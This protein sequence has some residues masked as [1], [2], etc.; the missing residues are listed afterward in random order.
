MLKKNYL[1]IVAVLLLAAV[2]VFFLTRKPV[3][4]APQP[5][6]SVEVEKD[7]AKPL[8]TDLTDP[9]LL[10][11]REAAD[12]FRDPRLKIL[13][14]QD[15]YTPS[16]EDLAGFLAA[17]QRS[18]ESLL[19]AYAVCKDPRVL[20]ELMTAAPSERTF[21]AVM[22]WSDDDDTVA[23]AT[24][25]MKK[26]SPKNPMPYLVEVARGGDLEPEQLKKVLE[27]IGDSPKID[28]SS[29]R[30]PA[31]RDEAWQSVVKDPVK[32]WAYSLQSMN[33]DL[34]TLDTVSNGILDLQ[35]SSQSDG[36]DATGFTKTLALS[37]ALRSDSSEISSIADPKVNG[38]EL[39]ILGAVDPESKYPGTSIKVQERIDQLEAK[40]ADEDSLDN[41]MQ[42]F[43]KAADPA[44]VE[45]FVTGWRTNGMN[46]ALKGL[47][48]GEKH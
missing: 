4:S 23:K 17:H 48:D 22:L 20:D 30:Q 25:E 14:Q 43:L 11:K 46:A 28:L 16:L 38:L 12:E 34:E 32:S 45:T 19:A 13:S 21:Q 3:A 37:K 26:L 1:W 10:P 35:M 7:P 2:A 40:M 6:P 5:P 29:L 24:E 33:L 18:P 36:N 44:A 42:E 27:M 15:D 9:A 47:G 39:E 31:L 41:Q 8:P